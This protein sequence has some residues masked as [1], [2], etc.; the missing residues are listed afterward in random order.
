MI[1]LSKNKYVLLFIALLAVS[2]SAWVVRFLPN[3]S[4][5]TIAFWRMFLASFMAFVISYKTILTFV[6]N[7]KILLAGVFLGFHFALFFRSV[8][9]TSIAEAALLG[10]IAPV[11]T[12]FYSI[13][14]QQ[15]R[16]SVRVFFGLSLAL[17]GAY[18]LISQSSFSETSM[19]GNLLAVLCSFA[20]A[21]VLLVGKD[22]RKSVGLFE[23]SRWLFLYAA[24]CLYLISLYQDVNVFFFS[25]HDFGWFVFLAA[26]PTMVGHNIF[27]FLVKTLSATTVAAVPL[28]EPVISSVGAF[29]LFN[30]PVSLF[31]FLGGSITLVGVYTIIRNDG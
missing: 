1:L 2:S 25:F 19:R 3:L 22:V 16:F 27:Y 24:A 10:T 4:A 13:V 21:V 7:K 15:K 18:I 12:E 26:I 11:F 6:P 23:Y 30:E 14:F 5:T 17:L 20:M 31:V 29:F 28:G 8:Q 9:L